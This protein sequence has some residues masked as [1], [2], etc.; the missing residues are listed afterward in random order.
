M[1]FKNIKMR[2]IFKFVKK[3]SCNYNQKMTNINI[4]NFLVNVCNRSF[5][6]TA[7]PFR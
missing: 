4:F 3:N 1:T 5:F 2:E 7:N 6:K